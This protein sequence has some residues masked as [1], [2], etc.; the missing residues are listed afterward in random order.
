MPRRVGWFFEPDSFNAWLA[1]I[2]LEDGRLDIAAFRALVVDLLQEKE[3][4]AATYLSMMQFDAEKYLDEAGPDEVIRHAWY[5]AAMAPRL[6][7]GADAPHDFL[8]SRVLQQAGWSSEGT[9][10]FLYGDTLASLAQ[11]SG[12]SAFE[13]ELAPHLD[14]YVFGGWLATERSV[15]LLRMLEDLRDLFERPSSEVLQGYRAE[16]LHDESKL[17]T[18]LMDAFNGELSLLEKSARRRLAVRI[19]ARY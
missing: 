10:Q 6:S 3:G 13:H 7:G 15:E 8:I 18:M 5:A 2:V 4:D 9:K 11:A 19:I 1:G 12:I 14:D 17:R 16:G